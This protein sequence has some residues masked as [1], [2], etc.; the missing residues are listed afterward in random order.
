MAYGVLTHS[1][2]CFCSYSFLSFLGFSCFFVF[3]R[4]FFYD[5]FLEEVKSEEKGVILNTEVFMWGC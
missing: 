5:V 4:A 2:M 3:A 1:H